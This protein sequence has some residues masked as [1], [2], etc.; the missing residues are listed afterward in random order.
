[1]LTVKGARSIR[2]AWQA[3]ISEDASMPLDTTLSSL[4]RANFLRVM[5]AGALVASSGGIARATV[6][7]N[8]RRIAPVTDL[9][10]FYDAWQERMNSR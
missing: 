10:A 7:T 2:K 4:T 8:A 6:A 3:T 9:D 1:M 5:A